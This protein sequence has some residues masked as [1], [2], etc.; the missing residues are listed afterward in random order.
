[1]INAYEIYV[2]KALI[3]KKCYIIYNTG[4]QTVNA[5]QWKIQGY[6]IPQSINDLPFIE[7]V[8]NA[9]LGIKRQEFKAGKNDPKYAFTWVGAWKFM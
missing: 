7:K 4:S 5:S 8:K 1:M 9:L 6:K 2:N 3:F